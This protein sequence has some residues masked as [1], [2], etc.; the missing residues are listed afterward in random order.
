MLSNSKR[1]VIEIPTS[2]HGNM[3]PSEKVITDDKYTE[4]EIGSM[5]QGRFSIFTNGRH[6]AIEQRW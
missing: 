5:V 4:Q 1:D 3:L 2:I 6:Q